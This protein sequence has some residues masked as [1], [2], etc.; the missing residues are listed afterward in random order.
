MGRDRKN[1]A[2]AAA[3]V[4]KTLTRSCTGS[5]LGRC[6]SPRKDADALRELAESLRV[7][8][9]PVGE[10]ENLARRAIRLPSVEA[11]ATGLRRSLFI[12]ESHGGHGVRDLD[13]STSG[14]ASI[15]DGNGANAFSKLSRYEATM[16]R[17][18]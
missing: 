9:Q 1:A 17:A 18:L 4:L 16:E 6:C 2:A 10:P 7:E 13:T 5:S 14:L 15:R 12:Q 11:P 8:L 3:A